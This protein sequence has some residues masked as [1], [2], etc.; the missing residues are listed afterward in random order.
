MGIEVKDQAKEIDTVDLM[1]EKF[2][3]AL[4][5]GYFMAGFCKN[6]RFFIVPPKS[7]CQQCFSYIDALEEIEPIGKVE[8]FSKPQVDVYG[9]KLSDNVF[10]AWIKFPRAVG[11]IIHFVEMPADTRPSHLMEV[12]AEFRPKRE[13]R[14]S[15]RDIRCFKKYID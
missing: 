7:F 3:N 8:S 11:G 10:V 5:D 14:G 9:N 12:V 2:L 6:C 1:V 13:R 15:L 4:R